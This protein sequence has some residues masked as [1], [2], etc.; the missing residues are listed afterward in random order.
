MAE[1]C[2]SKFPAIYFRRRAK[3]AIAVRVFLCW[4]IHSPAVARAYGSAFSLRAILPDKCCTLCR[5]VCTTWKFRS[6]WRT[7]A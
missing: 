6:F 4:H 5:R 7:I 1:L 2:C 3:G